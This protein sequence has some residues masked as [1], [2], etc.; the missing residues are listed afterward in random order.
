LITKTTKIIKRFI[1]SIRL[2]VHTEDE[3]VDMAADDITSVKEAIIA[4]ATIIAATVT[5]I[6]IA[7][8]TVAITITIAIAT[9]VAQTREAY[10]K[11]IV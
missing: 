9:T 7:W 8:A 11:A 10:K 6:T 2:T 5:V 4:T 3:A 1:I